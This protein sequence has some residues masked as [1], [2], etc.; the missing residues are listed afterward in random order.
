M[1][2]EERALR[3]AIEA[4]DGLQ[5][6]ALEKALRSK[7]KAK[8]KKRKTH[9]RPDQQEDRETF[10]MLVLGALALA[11]VVLIWKH[12][13]IEAWAAERLQLL[14]IR[15]R[16]LLP[17]GILAGLVLLAVIAFWVYRRVRRVVLRVVRMVR[18][19]R[20]LE[21]KPQAKKIVEQWPLLREAR[22]L[23]DVFHESTAK[24]ERVRHRDISWGLVI[25]LK[26]GVTGIKAAEKAENL[27][28]VFGAD[29]GA[30]RVIP[31]TKASRC[32]TVTFT[33]DVLEEPIRWEAP[34]TDK[35]AFD[36][37][38]T[39]LREDAEKSWWHPLPG[40]GQ[41]QSLFVGGIPRVGKSRYLNVLIAAL[42][43]RK[44]C[45]IA[46][47]DPAGTEFE[48]WRDCFAEGMLACGGE[49]FQEDARLVTLRLVLLFQRRLSRMR[50]RKERYWTPTAADPEVFFIVDELAECQ[51]LYEFFDLIVR[52]AP[53]C[54]IHCIMATQRPSVADLGNEGKLIIGKIPTRVSFHVSNST[55]TNVI[56]GAGA[57]GDGWHPEH[58]PGHERPGMY[59]VFP[60]DRFRARA[61]LISDEDVDWWCE[62]MAPT[63]PAL[64]LPA[65][66]TRKAVPIQELDVPPDV[67]TLEQLQIWMRMLAPA[68]GAKVPAG[69]VDEEP[70]EGFVDEE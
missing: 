44:D 37:I 60:D 39:G 1:D 31:D 8:S 20:G 7:K 3:A 22:E 47:I 67:Q 15:L 65:T 64:L 14:A 61:L 25:D 55:E 29:K 24:Q 40:P 34:P 50:E 4:S 51:L 57:I 13:A 33:E 54:G 18:K 30:T 12:A 38:L 53:K 41:A 17:L 43:A 52:G 66:S 69:V 10:K 42:V 49:T 27:D 21:E 23:R 16:H 68:S 36:P 48:S 58:L 56:L 45:A 19:M 2:R 62:E 46:G 28:S 59:L 63:R 26:G 32:H 6:I 70:I 11:V 35:T 5:R 9:L